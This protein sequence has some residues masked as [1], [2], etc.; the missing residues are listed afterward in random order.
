MRKLIDSQEN[1]VDNINVHL[2]DKL[3]PVF[4]YLGF[5]PNDITTLS[6]FFGVI[7]IILLATGHPWWFACTYY[8]SYF[9]DCMDGHFARRY[10]MVSKGGDYYDHIKD[11]FI[12]LGVLG[13]VF[14]R[15]SRSHSIITIIVA[16]LI[17]SIC[18]LL[19]LAHLGCQEKI[20]NNQD[21]ASLESLKILCPEDAEKN[22]KY[23]RWFGCGTFILI[24]IFFIIYLEIYDVSE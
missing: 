10:S 15:H 6:L 13:V 8:I 3:C 4:K 22:I 16:I 18:I 2:S 5:N 23:T 7:S 24:T 21:S 14:Y 20:S 12:G 17:Y 9:F 1:P 19:M 11:V